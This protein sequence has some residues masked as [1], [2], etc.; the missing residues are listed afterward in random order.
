[1]SSNGSQKTPPPAKP[2]LNRSL[3]KS[4]EHFLK[5]HKLVESILQGKIGNV[6]IPEDGAVPFDHVLD[7]VVERDNTLDYMDFEHLVELY[8]RHAPLLFEIDGENLVSLR[9]SN[10]GETVEPPEVLYFATVNGVA[11][12]VVEHGLQ[13]QK[14]PFVIMTNSK[15]AAI[16]RAHRFSANIKDGPALV[17]VRA[18]EAHNSGT[19]FTVGNREGLFLTARVSSDF[20]SIEAITPEQ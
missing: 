5:A 14:H 17:L 18:L 16:K 11:D 10:C 2:L 19:E 3:F 8:L 12:R 4:L 13:S 15:Q 7:L 6:P 1:M 9:P 20:L